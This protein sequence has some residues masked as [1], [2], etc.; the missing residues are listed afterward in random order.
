M[1]GQKIEREEDG[2]TSRDMM[3]SSA[4]PPMQS[5]VAPSF[6][7]AGTEALLGRVL[8][9]AASVASSIILPLALNQTIV[10]QF[11]FAQIVIAGVSTFGQLGLTFSIPATVTQAASLGDFGR[12][13]QSATR[14]LI[15]SSFAGLLGGGITWIVLPH[16]HPS[17][18]PEGMAHWLAAIPVIAAIIPLTTLSAVLIELLRAVHQ[19]RT[20]ANLATLATISTVAYLAFVL[21]AGKHASLVGVLLAGLGGA[22]FGVIIGTF[23]SFKVMQDWR[24]APKT[25]VKIFSIAA[26]TLPNLF[27][28]LMLFGVSQADMLLL[29]LFGEISDVAKY[30]I[31]LRFSAVLLI[32]LGIVNVAFAPLAV[33]L[34]T[35]RDEINL[36]DMIRK[37]VVLV[38]GSSF[39]LYACFVL[40]GHSLISLWNM[41]YLDSYKITL[42]LGAGQVLHA[43]GG[44]AGILLLVWGDQRY[45]L[46]LTLLTSALTILLCLIGLRFGGIVGLAAGAAFSNAFQIFCFVRR[47]RSRFGLDP[48]L[49]A[50]LRWA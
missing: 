15:L 39:F 27:T 21:F 25:P 11:F 33:Q 45:A 46:M 14:M 18:D 23:Q 17:L 32:P 43:C 41:G 12:A 26:Q 29:S 48:S 34:R 47:V 3:G 44:S 8:T 10:G 35:T 36:R 38:A 22:G 1:C 40:A 49:W 6:W 50:A 24:Q 28:T 16:L 42:I 7:K 13:K 30:G 19:I 2:R 5:F 20:A 9:I 31:A 37:L 4:K